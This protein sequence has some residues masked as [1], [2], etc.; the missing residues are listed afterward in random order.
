MRS[1]LGEGV[2][3]Q[4]GATHLQQRR[5]MQPAFHRER[6]ASYGDIMIAETDALLKDWQV[7][8]V[9]PI[10]KEMRDLTFKIVSRTFFSD[11]GE[12]AAQIGAAFSKVQAAIDREFDKY[13]LLPNWVPVMRFGESKKAVETMQDITE[14][15][16]K[17]R[18]KNLV[19]TGDLLSMLL[20]SKDE[21]G[22]TLS[23]QQVVAQ[24]L[25]LLFAGHETTA[26][27]LNWTFYLLS[28][29]PEVITKL[30]EEA[31]EVLQT[32][33]PSFANY[34]QL[35]Y[36]SWVINEVLRLYPPAYYAERAP[37]EAVEL[38]GHSFKAHTPFV[39]SVYVTQR[40]P[41]FFINPDS[42]DPERFSPGRISHIPKYAYAPFGAGSHQC[43]GNQFA[44]LEAR[45]ILARLMQRLEFTFTETTIQ[46]RV[47]VT[48][49]IE[50][51]LKIRVTSKT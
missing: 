9:K 18:Q 27:M 34:S 22:S 25:T 41:H 12:E 50:D 14:R 49:G 48:Y 10:P 15:I 26:N 3:S 51:G 4:E 45:L 17:E 30:R 42:F 21:D 35:N 40:D 28:Q 8:D 36:T 19:D 32:E 29:H 13:A 37:L 31:K 5:L 16:V 23:T 44:L 7:G 1:F 6:L 24:T 38:N 43:I 39:I 20:F 46:P 47:A 11:R 33:A 2:L